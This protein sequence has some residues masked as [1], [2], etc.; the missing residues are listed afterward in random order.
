MVVR[1]HHACAAGLSL[2]FATD[3]KQSID[4]DVRT[5]HYIAQ[6]LNETT[7]LKHWIKDLN[8]SHFS[9]PIFA[10]TAFS[11]SDKPCM[12]PIRPAST[13]TF[14][15]VM[16]QSVFDPLSSHGSTN[17][18]W[19][20]LQVAECV[21]HLHQQWSSNRCNAYRKAIERSMIHHL[22]DRQ[23]IYEQ[24]TRFRDHPFWTDRRERCHLLGL[25]NKQSDHPSQSF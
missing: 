3:L 13:R 23:Q 1:S 8:L 22:N 10:I 11:T 21:D 15:L 2:F 19:S 6:K 4:R 17:A 12:F 5:T 7:H 24:E 9:A 25:C 16:Q 14:S 18:I 20:G